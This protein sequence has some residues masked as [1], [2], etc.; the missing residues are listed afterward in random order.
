MASIRA[1]LKIYVVL[2]W[3]ALAPLV[4]QSIVGTDSVV[5]SVVKFAGVLNDAGG[6]PLG[7]TVGVTFLL[8]KEQAG[9]APLWVETQ[10][11][12]IDPTGHYAVMLGSTTNHGIPADAFAAG[13]ARWVGVQASGQA[14]QERVQLVSVPYA[15]K[16]ADAQTLGGLPASAFLLA[17]PSTGASNTAATA[18]SPQSSGAT[19]VTTPGGTVNALAKFDGAADIASSQVFDT[20]AGVGIGTS[21]PVGKLDVK[22]ASTLR[23]AVT[24]PTTGNATAAAGKNSQPLNLSASAFN[25]SIGQALNETFRWQTEPVGNNTAAPLS[26]LS[27][28]FGLGSNTPSETGFSI[29]N[30]GIINF[31]SSQTFPATG[32]GTVKSVGLSAPASDFSVSASP[33]TSSGTLNLQWLIPPTDQ[34]TPSAIVKRDI[35][36]GFQVAQI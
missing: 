9:G 23:G 34:P 10:N 28:L 21:T 11:V 8:Y 30:T 16:A 33:V 13:E 24:L 14:E 5:P 19:T 35:F 2:I 26:K 20:G 15:L 6:K 17:Q 32:N 1:I 27:L 36:G 31:A 18:M 22:G 29:S 7:G 3:C 12:R 25:S 4:A